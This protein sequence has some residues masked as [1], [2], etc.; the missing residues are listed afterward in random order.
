[1]PA[2]TSPETN[3]ALPIAADLKDVHLRYVSSDT[4][5]YTRKAWGKGFRYFDQ[6]GE[7]IRDDKLRDW[8]TSLVIPPAWEDVWISPYKNG[9][10]LVT[11]RD[12]RR[13]KQ[14]IYHPKWNALRNENKFGELQ[15]FGACLP[16]IRETTDAHLRQQTLSRTR[17][18]AAVVRLLENTLIRIG[19]DEYARAN[20]SYG[21]TTLRDKH[22][23]ID[24]ATI[25]FEFAG[26]SGKD[27]AITLHDRRLARVV[28]QS[29]D[30]PGYALFQYHDENGDRQEID[31]SDVNS[32]LHE[33]TGER[34]TAKI[35]RTWGASSNAIKYLCENCADSRTEKSVKAC[36][37]HVAEALGNTKT[38]SRKYYI[39]PAI[40]DA[41]LSGELLPLYEKFTK[42]K[43]SSS[44]YGLT[45]EEKTLIALIE[46]T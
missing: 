26:K 15:Q 44:P 43:K 46:R 38:V 6:H 36:V 45:P 8:I 10:I 9:H 5:G 40:M 12:S 21:L 28:K 19:N 1:M 24:G 17:V 11:G 7:V 34:F 32:Y 14:Y 31:S 27:H 4:P 2:N 30:I 41:Q 3:S 20:D 25:T 33:I 16:V 37:A 22:T 13:R 29:R 23:R 42:Q 18:L 35:F 39:H